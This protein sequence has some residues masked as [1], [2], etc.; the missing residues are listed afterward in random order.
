MSIHVKLYGELKDKLEEQSYSAGIPSTTYVKYN[1]NKVVSD[2]LKKLNLLGYN[3][4][5]FSLSSG[6]RTDY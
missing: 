6:I 5:N 4:N 3:L 1:E 2:I